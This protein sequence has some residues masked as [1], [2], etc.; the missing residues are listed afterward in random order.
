MIIISWNCRGLGQPRAVPVLCE[1]IRTHKADVVF[2]SE[3]LVYSSRIEEIRVKLGFAGALSVDR[4]GR[5]GGLALLWRHKDLCTIKDFSRNHINAEI[6]EDDK[7]TWRITCFYGLPERQRKRDS[8]NLLQ[9][10]SGLSNLPWCCIGDFNDILSFEEKKRRVEHPQWLINGFRETISACGLIDLP[11]IG[12]PFTW[13]RSRGTPNAVEER[14]DR[15]LAIPSW[16]SIFPQAKLFNQSAPL[17][18]HNPILLQTETPTQ[19]AKRRGFRFENTWLNEPGFTEVVKQSWEKS[20]VTRLSDRLAMTADSLQQW[21]RRVTHKYRYEIEKCKRK[22]EELRSRDDRESVNHL[23]ETNS[24]LIRLLIQEE[25]FWKQRAKTYWLKEGDL[26]SK[27]FHKTATIRKESNKI[28]KL[29]DGTGNSFEHIDDLCR[30]AKQH[31]TDVYSPIMANC[32][33][34]ISKITPMVSESDKRDLLMPLR[35]DEVKEALF[36]MHGDKSPGPHGYNPAFFQKFWNLVEQDVFNE[37]SNWWMNCC[38][39]EHLNDTHIALIPKGENHNSMNDFRPISLSNEEECGIL[40]Q[41]LRDY[42][43]ASGQ[44]INFSKSGIMFSSNLAREDQQTLSDIFGIT[45]DMRAG[46]YLGLPSLIGKNKREIFNYIKDRLWKRIHSWRGKYLSKAGREIL[47][48]SVAQALPSYCMNV[49]L[50]PKS[51]IDELQRIMNSFWWGARPN[52]NRGIKWLSWERLC[53]RKIHGGMSFR[54]LK[55]FNLAMLGKQAWNL[56]S[57]PLSL[58]ARILKAKYFPIS[59]FMEA[60]L[61]HN[62]SYI[63][64]SLWNSKF[65]M[66]KGIRWRVGDGHNIRVWKDPWLRDSQNFYLDSPPVIG[67]ESMTVNELI[68]PFTHQWDKEQLQVLFG[69]RDVREIVVSRCLI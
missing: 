46:K 3:T 26:N 50:L 38:F 7:P 15:A 8:W 62:P 20:H 17:S 44:S 11:L 49:F 41:L 66:N 52:G 10:L 58:M 53:T 24:K 30:I 59:S 5:S 67:M 43:K 57:K 37:C 9:R 65:I 29:T 6:K 34:V 12:Y 69:D 19:F 48:K 35:T 4:V 27:F 33:V 55:S 1:L 42:E 60:S 31:Y 68:N 21:G 2:L 56:I 40:K 51:T 25:N 32:E 63:W 18:D 22:I 13:G 28:K 54:N 39:P 61:G 45:K 16:S 14:I 36:Q 47:I 23:Q 64:R